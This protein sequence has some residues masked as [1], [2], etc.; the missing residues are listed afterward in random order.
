MNRIRLGVRKQCDDK[1]PLRTIITIQNQI[2]KGDLVFYTKSM[3]HIFGSGLKKSHT[4]PK[5]C[6]W[7]SK[8]V[9]F[10]CLFVKH[11]PAIRNVLFVN[12]WVLPKASMGC[13]YSVIRLWLSKVKV[14]KTYWTVSKY[15]EHDISWTLLNE[16][17]LL[18]A[19]RSMLSIVQSENVK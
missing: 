14:T 5:E 2:L 8:P 18:P 7:A 13:W 3:L 6:Y 1:L 4:V 12:S 10:L 11:D 19:S 15:A 9:S 17:S 16:W